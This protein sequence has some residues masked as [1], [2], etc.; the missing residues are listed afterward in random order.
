MPCLAVQS[1]RG[2]ATPAD[3]P[4]RPP[5]RSSASTPP[6]R[7]P[8]PRSPSGCSASTSP[9]RTAS[10]ASSPTAATHPNIVPQ[11]TAGRWYVRA[12]DLAELAELYPGAALLRGRS[13][14]DRGDARQLRRAG[15]G[16]LGV[17][18]RPRARRHLPVRRRGHRSPLPR[19]RTRPRSS[20]GRP[21]W[22]TC[23]C[24][25]PTIHPMLA[26]DAGG[27]VNH[28]PEFTAA[29]ITS[30]RPSADAAPSA[31]G[32]SR[33]PSPSARA[34]RRWRCCTPP[35]SSS[36]RLRRAGR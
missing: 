3:P 27:A 25:C 22:P 21:T 29:C 30:G 32:P 7:S 2:A 18:R 9:R 31:T 19:P 26:I 24:G 34:P 10:T 8:S 20:P 28:Q 11:R 33:W 16:L 17:P 15:P 1:L 23:R 12:A 13:D 35:R 5:T 36:H 6:T 4:T 14:R